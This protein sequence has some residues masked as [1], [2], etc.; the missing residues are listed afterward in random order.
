MFFFG[1]NSSG[2]LNLQTSDDVEVAIF[3]VAVYGFMN[4]SKV[5]IDFDG[6]LINEDFAL[7]CSWWCLLT[8]D[9]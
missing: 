4:A 6:V 3:P 2:I 5:S 9:D 7:Y 8:I 1:S